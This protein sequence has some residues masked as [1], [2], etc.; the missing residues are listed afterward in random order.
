MN[1]FA[2]C[3]ENQILAFEKK[4]HV[5][6]PDCYKLFL[7]KINGAILEEGVSIPVP[8]TSETICVDTVYGL[9]PGN[10]WIDMDYWH[11][12]HGDELPPGTLIIGN[13]VLTGF[14]LI[15]DI[16]EARGVYYWDDKL[17][18]AESTAESNCYYICDSV[19]EYLKMLLA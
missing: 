17:N 6:I 7:T 4:H 9:G 13:D 5:R 12:R 2:K 18:F 14:L 19:E 11:E 10:Q 16:P 3:T 15:L 8:S 1:T